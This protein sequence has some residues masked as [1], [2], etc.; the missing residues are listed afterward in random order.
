MAKQLILCDCS[1]SQEIDSER[2]SDVTGLSC[3][4]MHSALC[5]SQTDSAA[6]AIG[7]GD[8]VIC[9]TQEQ[10]LFEE[11]AGEIGAP[12][13]AFLD[14]RDRAGWTADEGD[15]LPKM[16]ALVAEAALDTSA[17]KTVDVVSEGLCLIV[18]SGD[19]ALAAAKR[20]QESLAVTVLLTG[21]DEP[22]MSRDFDVVR[23]QLRQAS[24]ALGQFQV[25]IDALQQLD[26]TGRSWSWTAPRD[27][28]RS[29]CDIILDLTGGTPLFPAH[30]KREGYLRADP[31]GVQAVADAVLEAS[32]L[33]GTFEKPLYVR[34]EPL[35]C[36]HSRA[37]QTGCTNCLDVCP[38][39]AISPNGDHVSIDPMIC[40][41]CGACASLCPSGSITYDAPPTDTLMRR[42]QV[43]AKA[44]LDAGGSAPRL[45]VVNEHG[46][47]MIRLAARFGRGLPA[48][49]LP[50]ELEA[51]NTFGH[52]EILAALAAGFAHVSLL[53]SP[54]VDRAVQERELTLA[55]AIAGDKATLLDLNDPDALSDALFGAEVP[56]PIN[57]PL[58]PMGTRRQIT[59][60][61]ARA[62]APE[63][64]MLPLPDDAPYG[65]VLVDTDSCTLCLSCVSLCPSGALGDNPDLPQLRFQEDAC[66]QCGLCANVCP[67][68]AISYEPRL[69]LQPEALSQVVVH[70]EEPF[71]CVECGTL[72]GVKSTIERITEK[73]AGKHAM[74]ATSDAA[75]MIQM[76]DDCRVNAQFHQ[77]N[78]PF[79]GKERP[80]VRT[81]AD[82]LSKRRDH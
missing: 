7:A 43:L 8:A 23:G 74:F 75:R 36:A 3:S 46:A 49:V 19:V 72:F 65:A 70:E 81:T 13:P 79:E 58:R 33:V 76:C 17:A 48:D 24:G 60:Q 77:E 14:L 56:A 78:N 67:E 63:A 15:L 35:L 54:K 50:L 26:T 10:R 4:K 52:A 39:G 45:L 82:Y 30:E 6:A 42:I 51:M 59:R 80:R 9:C 37:S 29:E 31:K 2:L 5:T 32:Q 53:M 28:G 16:S 64:D 73:L 38:T 62:L 57:E 22:P 61:A 25:T 71:A 40:A 34:S 27:G 41:G 47:E 66:L 44:Y 18:G 21:D 68:Q 11:I 20:L 12:S 1:G 69:N 55:Q